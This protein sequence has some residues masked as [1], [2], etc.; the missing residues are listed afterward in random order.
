ML[1]LLDYKIEKKDSFNVFGRIRIHILF[2]VGFF[3]VALFFGQLVF[4][5][6]LATDGEKLSNI[7]KQIK[8]IQEE[9]VNLKVEVAKE[10]SL[11]TISKKAQNL[12]FSKPTQVIVPQSLLD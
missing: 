3:A 6:K 10:S 9:N 8:T 12:G 1:P 5:N 11:V 4:A 2:I 7:E